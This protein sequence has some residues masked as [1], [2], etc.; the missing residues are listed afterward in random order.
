M[1]RSKI[2]ANSRAGGAAGP[3]LEAPLTLTPEQIAEV[4]AG[5]LPSIGT[6][7]TTR[8]YSPIITLS[9]SALS[10]GALSVSEL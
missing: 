8:G 4:A 7:G 3:Q 2:A 5:A 1:F 6:G 10:V 9:G